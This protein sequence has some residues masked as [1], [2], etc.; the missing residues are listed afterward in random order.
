FQHAP[1]AAAPSAG[2]QVWARYMHG[3]EPDKEGTVKFA[4]FTLLG[5]DFG[6]MD[7]ARMHNF[8]FNE[9]ISLMIPCDTQEEI[10]YFWGKLSANPKAEQC[11]WLK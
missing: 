4:S 9:A 2:P 5:Q 6:T 3:E 8:Q 1:G 11:G 7:S 10:D